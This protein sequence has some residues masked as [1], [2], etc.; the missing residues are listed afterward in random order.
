MSN[1]VGKYI[2]NLQVEA[3]GYKEVSLK[4]IVIS[5]SNPVGSMRF[6]PDT[7]VRKSSNVRDRFSCS[8]SME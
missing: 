7:N 2:V 8:P 4:S 3:V 5:F 6:A 1:L